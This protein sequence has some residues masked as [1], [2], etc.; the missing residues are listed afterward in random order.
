[1]NFFLLLCT[2]PQNTKYNFLHSV[3][4]KYVV[5]YCKVRKR[6]FHFRT[7]SQAWQMIQLFENDYIFHSYHQSCRLS[8]NS[9]LF[10]I[11]SCSNNG[12]NEDSQFLPIFQFSCIAIYQVKSS[13][14]NAENT[15][16]D[17]VSDKGARWP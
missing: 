13:N 12:R 5:F 17:N 6:N 1:M 10:F 8:S 16:A 7:L 3:K 11:L 14:V 4:K 2:V 9:R 15:N